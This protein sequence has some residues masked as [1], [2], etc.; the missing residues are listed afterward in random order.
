MISFM[1]YALTFLLTLAQAVPLSL[2]DVV[3]PPI[4]S[5][6]ASTV[7]TVGKTVTVTWNMTGL[8]TPSN[9]TGKV[10]LGYST[11]E[12]E[13]LDIDSPLAQ[14]FSL[15]DGQVSFV[16]PSVPNRTNYIVAL[17]G[18]SGNISPNFTITGTT[19]S[20]AS[21]SSSFVSSSSSI[22]SSSASST[23]ASSTP[24]VS[25]SLG[26]VAPASVPGGTSSL[27]TPGS[28]S[29]AAPLSSGP[30]LGPSECCY[31]LPRV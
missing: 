31:Y 15:S 14:N 23:L 4:T 30:S 24:S 2:R 3:D 11:Y 28:S 20:S 18:D 22:D 10:V 21:S 1:L 27:P 5:P 16:V 9:P 19:S 13:N 6:D 12:S 7:W 25:S 17:F 26:E 29:S 8:S